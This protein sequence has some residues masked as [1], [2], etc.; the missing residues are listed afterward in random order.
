VSI[1]LPKYSVMRW[2]AFGIAFTPLGV[3]LAELTLLL[4]CDTDWLWLYDS[5]YWFIK[6]LPL[7]K[8]CLPRLRF[9][10]FME[11]W[12]KSW[13]TFELDEI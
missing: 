12:L 7:L 2:L 13:S 9:L 10:C 4:A 3:Y 8:N 1:L 5:L 11:I 6:T